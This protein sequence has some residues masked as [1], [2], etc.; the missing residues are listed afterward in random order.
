LGVYYIPSTDDSVIYTGDP[1]VLTGTADSTG[2]Y[3]TVDILVDDTSSQKIVGVAMGFS[4]VPEISAD[5]S[6]LLRS[7]RPASTAMYVFVADDPDTVFECQEDGTMG[8][9]GVGSNF[10]LLL[11][12]GS[13]VT[14]RSGVEIDSSDAAVTQTLGVK[15]LRAVNAD[16]NDAT[17]ANARWE[18]LINT[19]AY[20]NNFDGTNF[21]GSL[22]V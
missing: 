9:A 13:T 11:G 7:Y 22:G 1:V 16:D 6:N 20:R 10:N 19:H 2:R 17:L 18:I 3:P 4:T 14:G 8:V 5:P 12:T 15:V 21:A